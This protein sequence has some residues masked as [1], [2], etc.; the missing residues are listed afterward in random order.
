[1]DFEGT[2][3]F[4]AHYAPFLVEL[5]VTNPNGRPRPGMA[6]KLRQIQ[7]YVEVLSTIVDRTRAGA[8]ARLRIVDVGCGRGYLTF[9]AHAYFS[10]RG[11]EV[12]GRSEPALVET[13]GVEVRPDLVSETNEI[14]QRLSFDGLRFVESTIADY[15]MTR[16]GDAFNGGRGRGDSS[17]DGDGDGGGD[18]AAELQEARG[19]LGGNEPVD[20]L[21]ALHACDTATDD[22]L[23][24]GI[25]NGAQIH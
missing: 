13:V 18:S 3:A 12:A 20:C 24:C 9:A 8:S 22:A 6:N 16:D 4:T 25:N 5:G 1:M 11:A 7:R 14:A 2:R 15:L 21:I 19:S 23:W 17:G 10:T